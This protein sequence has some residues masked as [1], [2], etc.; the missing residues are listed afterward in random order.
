[1]TA[2]YI[3]GG[4]KKKKDLMHWQKHIQNIYTQ[5]ILKVS[6]ELCQKHEM[7]NNTLT[8]MQCG[9]IL[10]SRRECNRT[11][12]CQENIKRIYVS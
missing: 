6:Q 1:M 5:H 12:I 10:T 9:K 4:R 11:L 3:T 7:E 8:L 2:S